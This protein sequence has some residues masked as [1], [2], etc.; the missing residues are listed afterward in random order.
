MMM[1]IFEIMWDETDSTDPHTLP[2]EVVMHVSKRSDNTL[3]RFAVMD[4][5]DQQYNSRV[6]DFKWEEI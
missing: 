5:L 4:E 6:E 3:M 2:Q 1:R